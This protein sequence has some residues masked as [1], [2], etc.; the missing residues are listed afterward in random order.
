MFCSQGS[1]LGLHI[2][3]LWD[4]KTPNLMTL[5]CRCLVLSLYWVMSSNEYLAKAIISVARH[6]EDPSSFAAHAK[7]AAQE[8][9]L[10]QAQDLPTYFHEN[11]PVPEDLRDA[12]AQQ[13][14]LGVWMS[15]CQNVIF[16]ILY[17]YKEKALPILYPVAFGVYD[18]T[19]YKAVGVLCKLAAEGVATDEIVSQIQ[20]H[21]GKFRE[22]ALFPSL[23][24]LSQ[25]KDN[26]TVNAIYAEQYVELKK[27]DSVDAYEALKYWAVNYP[28]AVREHL[29]FLKDMALGR[30]EDAL[31]NEERIDAAALFHQ[32]NPGDEEVNRLLK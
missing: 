22:E 30:V 16:E 21:I 12:L 5:I 13:G 23:Y 14:R 2:A 24:Y 28:D 1:A 7:Q 8:L 20:Q 27:Y 10:D 19:Q 17:H 26:A 31:T 11:P 32:L 9:S 6:F 25:I 18:W 3:S 29:P 4:F 15:V